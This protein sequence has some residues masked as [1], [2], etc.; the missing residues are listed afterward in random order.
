VTSGRA[1]S[2]PTGERSGGGGAAARRRAPRAPL[3]I[4]F[5]ISITKFSNSISERFTINTPTFFTIIN[6]L[7]D[8]V[9]FFNRYN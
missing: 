5:S 2:S 9:Y 4:S 8:T 3:P 7:C 6:D 1:T